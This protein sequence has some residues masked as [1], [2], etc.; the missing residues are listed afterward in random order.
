M[1]NPFAADSNEDIKNDELIRQ[2]LSGNKE[3]LEH[4]ILRHQAWIYNIAF[5]MVLVAEDAEDVT[6]EILI[7]MI[8]KLSTYD[9]KKAS[10][11]TWLYRIVVNHV[12]NMKKR[13]YEE[14][15]SVLEDYYSFIE[16]IPDEEITV[17]PEIS[18][19]INDVIVGC[20]LGALLC[21]DRKQR[22][23]FVL[24]VVF[25]VTSKQGSEV[26]GVSE[27]SFRK[28]LSRARAKLYNFMNNKCGLVNKN[29]PCKCRNKVSE[30]I[31]QGWHTIDNIHFYRE[32]AIKVNELISEKINKFDDA[33]YSD[34]IKLY[35]NHPFYEPP[36]LT[37][38]IK[39][40]LDRQEFKEIFDLN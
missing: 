14:A 26:M 17:T 30:F 11:R 36:D 31:R 20:V 9:S 10:F 6:Q 32:N 37:V 16:K 28:T 21:L 15:V 12:I 33:V 40:I 22:V 34:F 5:R 23:V 25:N 18:L 39:N 1:Y 4:L 8:T 29:A 19:I 2:A 3:A 27:V 13:G 35:R 24:R 38:W 7:K